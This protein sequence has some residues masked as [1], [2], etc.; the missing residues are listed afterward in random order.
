MFENILTLILKK[1]LY[2]IIFLFMLIEGPTTNFIASMYSAT[3]NINIFIIAVMAIIGDFL[4]DCIYYGIG[5]KISNKKY[6][7]KLK[8]AKAK[9]LLYEIE[10]NLEKNLFISLSIIK[11]APISGIGLIYA[12]KKKIQFKKFAIFSIILCILIDIPISLIGFSLIISLK[13]FLGIQNNLQL[14][15]I[16]IIILS[17]IGLSLSPMKNYLNKKYLKIL[18]RVEK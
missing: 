9:K 7:K 1:S 3:S 18:K 11:I 10:K 6:N 5:R 13:T 14:I 16:I 17:L 2:P 4:G 12:G 15:G 8:K